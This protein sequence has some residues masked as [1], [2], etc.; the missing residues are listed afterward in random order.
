MFTES[1]Q[2]VKDDIDQEYIPLFGFV[3][4]LT[5]FI[6]SLADCSAFSTKSLLCC[7]ECDAKYCKC[8]STNLASDEYFMFNEGRCT[9]KGLSTCIRS[10]LQI[11][12]ID[13]RC[14]LPLEDEEV[15]CALSIC[16]LTCCYRLN[17]VLHCCA[18]IRTLDERYIVMND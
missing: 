6:P 7:F 11:C 2:K 9:L 13:Q 5:S 1:L 4:C 3:C 14:A 16:G 15:P 8:R 18:N 12:C 17:C 10:N